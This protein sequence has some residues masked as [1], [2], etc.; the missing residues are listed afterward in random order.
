MDIGNARSLLAPVVASGEVPPIEVARSS[1]FQDSA[2]LKAL[3]AFYTP[4]VTADFLA[5][6]A[7]KSGSERILEPSAGDG[8][9]I[10]AALRRAR[11]LHNVA[12]PNVVACDIDPSAIE[13]IRRSN[14]SEVRAICTDFLTIQKGAI[15]AFDLVLANPPFTRNHQLSPELRALLRKGFGISGAP[16]IWVHFLLHAATFLRDGGR[17]VSVVPRAAL[18]SN[19]AKEFLSELE[20]KFRQVE[21]LAF[22]NRVGW[23]GD[24]QEGGA[25]LVADGYR[26]IANTR[27]RVNNWREGIIDDLIADLPEKPVK[28][29]SIAVVGIGIVTGRNSIFLLD[30]A[31]REAAG[32]SSEDVTPIVSRA[33]HVRG[34][35]INRDMLH[36]LAGQG[37]R[38]L[39]LTPRRLSPKVKAYLSR[40]P[41]N[42]IESVA[43]FRKRKPWWR[44]EIGRDCHAV[45]TS[46]NHQAPRVAQVAKGICC[47][48][49]LIQLTFKPHVRA[50]ATL[51]AI[52]AS[53]SSFGQLQF[54]RLGR[55]YGHGLLKLEPSGVKDWLVPQ[56]SSLGTRLELNRV[57]RDLKHC[58]ELEVTRAVDEMIFAPVLGP[59]WRYYSEKMIE[60]L[61]E[62][63]R[64]RL[65]GRHG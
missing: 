44:V 2:G 29:A 55:I 65:G 24:A 49:T 4:E 36:R 14:A 12:A 30:E 6:L 37:E 42:D 26:E 45:V 3:G 22:R 7:I 46:M 47:T 23:R 13:K 27:T 48:N 19:Y 54:E 35:R 62:L 50:S 40:V 34:P 58:D 10:W 53:R 18:Y 16:G 59:K 20:T 21:I 63:R 5:A 31:E 61:L 52:I 25:I 39:L 43:W 1:E 32:I 60:E 33:R 17:I 38:T 56:W 11:S 8:A 41:S 51:A 28:L 15:G 57:L 64:F 9:L